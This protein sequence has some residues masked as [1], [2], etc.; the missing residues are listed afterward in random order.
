MKRSL[1]TAIALV[2]VLAIA[3]IAFAYHGSGCPRKESGVCP[4]TGAGM[5]ELSKEDAERLKAA[6]QR[7]MDETA[8]LRQAVYEKTAALKAELAKKTPDVAKAS[9]IQKE[10][11][12]IEAKLDQKNLEHVIEMKK[13]APD[14]GRYFM[15]YHGGSGGRCA[16]GGALRWPLGTRSWRCVRS[17]KYRWSSSSV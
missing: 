9:A 12:D 15:R 7:Y 16:G 14:C 2:S 8:D 4:R 13:I 1:M 17:S 5:A 11:S 10:I 3:S 6:G